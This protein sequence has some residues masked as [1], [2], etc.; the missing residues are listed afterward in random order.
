MTHLAQLYRR[1]PTSTFVEQYDSVYTTIS[2]KNV[3][4]VQR[5]TAAVTEH[6]PNFL[7][8]VEI[9]LIPQN[10]NQEPNCLSEIEQASL[11]QTDGGRAAYIYLFTCFIGEAM[12]WGMKA[13][14][15]V[16]L[17]MSLISFNQ[18]FR[19]HMVSFKII[20]Q[21]QLRSLRRGIVS[22]WSELAQRVSCI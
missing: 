19:S 10:N 17:P 1:L 4:D 15:S 8:N 6:L 22:R 11:P 16:V 9:E 14:Y 18:L 20:T 2:R 5:P 21:R 12:V 13:S 7:S 3:M